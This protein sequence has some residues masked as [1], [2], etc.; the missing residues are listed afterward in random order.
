MRDQHPPRFLQRAST[1]LIGILFGLVPVAQAQ[2]IGTLDPSFGSGGRVQFDYNS[3]DSAVNAIG[4]QP[5]TGKII[6]GGSVS[7]NTDGVVFRLNADGSL[8]TSFASNGYRVIDTGTSNDVT[9]ILV[10]ADS[11]ILV[12][13]GGG[14]FG[15]LPVVRLTSG[16]AFDTTFSDD[17][18]AEVDVNGIGVGQA[19]ALQGENVVVATALFD[20]EFAVVRLT[21]SGAL[22]T[23]FNAG[24]AVP[25]IA[26][27]DPSSGVDQVRDVAVD[28]ASGKIVVVGAAGG[29]F[30]IGRFNANGTVDTGFG[31]NGVLLVDF[32]AKEDAAN[33][34]AIQ[35]NGKIVVAGT[36]VRPN[37][38][39]RGD[40]AVVRL[41]TNGTLDTTFDGD[42]RAR[43][44]FSGLAIALDV[45]VQS[46]GKIVL[47]GTQ[48]DT[49]IRNFAL[50]RLTAG[51]AL[52]T[53][54]VGEDFSAYPATQRINFGSPSN[55][56]DVAS[57]LVQQSDGN[58][59][60]GGYTALSD[61]DFAF[62]RFFGETP[63]NYINGTPNDDELIGTP[64]NDYIDG[65]AGADIM[66]GLAG[67]DT[68]VVDNSG[69]N[70]IEEPGEGTDTV[71]SS[72]SYTLPAHVEKL[73]LTG[74]AAIN[75]TGNGLANTLTGNSG[76][77]VLD[78]KGGADTMAG[79]AG[80]DTYVVE[81]A[82]DKVTEGVDQGTDS[83]RS[84][85][86]YTLPS[87]VE[88]LVLTGTGAINGTGN[89]LANKI[90]GNGADNVINGGAGSDTLAGR[91]GRDSFLFNKP[92]GSTNID[93]ITDFVPADDTIRLENAV[94]TAL[95]TTGTLASAAFVTG[96][97]ATTAAHRIIY[98]PATGNVRYDADGAGGA[99]A[100]RFALLPAKP[101]LSRTDFYVQ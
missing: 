25:G 11:R 74:S 16:G 39:A 99:A 36:A 101:A 1:G 78:G 77:N 62:A 63:V 48:Q 14:N 60:L 22:D 94:F 86:T 88:N 28:P 89:A 20:G 30:A 6:A 61:S 34:V 47:G 2:V 43:V 95:T 57:G 81:R 90:T 92:L 51:G 54:F 5:S 33:A 93:K 98:D 29:D 85:V 76:N 79:K 24:G 52:D 80:D 4:L 8:D 23:T 3:T 64:G 65:K 49:S 41:N 84:S 31:T 10:M 32:D 15:V 44:P 87:N 68:Y 19:V 26:A 18:I 17:G 83:I 71:R 58:Y 56:D 91:A 13:G 12:A 46:D 50:A 59:V 38:T 27:V 66:V 70:A 45:F 100:V 67:D 40:F 37:E 9:D 75:G 7:A 97:A 55:R 42:G 96:T 53:T 72:I 21:S 35:S 73:L 82:G 69:D